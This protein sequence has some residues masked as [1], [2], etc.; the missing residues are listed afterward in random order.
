MGAISFEWR[1]RVLGL[2]L[3]RFSSVEIESRYIWRRRASPPTWALLS[4]RAPRRP[5][6]THVILCHC[7]KAAQLRFEKYNEATLE[8]LL[9]LRLWSLKISH[10]SLAREKNDV[11]KELLVF[12]WIP[13]HI[14]AISLVILHHGRLW[15]LL[16]PLFARLSTQS[17]RAHYLSSL[18]V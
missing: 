11:V 12:F 17:F 18:Y 4:P 5:R 16:S 6:H 2:K 10:L 13:P 1:L 3:A 8:S 15:S 14:L 7:R 9:L